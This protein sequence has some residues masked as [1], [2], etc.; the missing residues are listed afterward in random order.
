MFQT[1]AYTE[2]WNNLTDHQKANVK[3][4]SIEFSV[5]ISML[6]IAAA[7]K[8]LGDDNKDDEWIAYWNYQASRMKTDMWFYSNP[9]EAIKLLK[10]PMAA[11]STLESVGKLTHQVLTD[12][13]ADYKIGPHKGEN[14]AA[15]DFYDLVPVY[16]QLYRNLID[17][18]SWLNK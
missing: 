10:S 11:V 16:R 14:K 9:W 13:F 17:E 1:V 5:M 15:K 7:M 8:D 6:F 3:R 4:F 12:P 18:V 2:E